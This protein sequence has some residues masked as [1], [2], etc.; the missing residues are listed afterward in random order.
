[1]ISSKPLCALN[2]G[3]IAWKSFDVDDQGIEINYAVCNQIASHIIRFMR[4]LVM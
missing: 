2:E 4:L 1:M 3:L